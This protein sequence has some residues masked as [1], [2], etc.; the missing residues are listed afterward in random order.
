MATAVGTT[1]PYLRE[2]ADGEAVKAGLR[3]GAVGV[4]APGQV[5][6]CLFE[7]PVHTVHDSA[8]QRGA[9]RV[10][11]RKNGE[12]GAVELVEDQSSPGAQCVPDAVQG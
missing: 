1:G 5:G 2:A 3:Q 6:A 9:R 8:E 10:R 12:P 7:Q 11:C 4:A